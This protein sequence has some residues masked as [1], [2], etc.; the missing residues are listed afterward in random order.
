MNRDERTVFSVGAF[1]AFADPLAEGRVAIAAHP[2]GWRQG[3][4]SLRPIHQQLWLAMDEAL[5]RRF[6][7]GRREWE[8]H[9]SR[10]P[11]EVGRELDAWIAE[12]RLEVRAFAVSAVEARPHGIR[13]IAPD[14]A[15]LNADRAVLATGPDEDAAAT[16]LLR[17]GIGDGLLRPGPMGLGIDADPMSLRVLDG[18]GSSGRPIFALGPVLRGVLWETIAVP[19]IRV[20]A[21]AIARVLLP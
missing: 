2:D 13:L 19:E 12:G 1:R 9:R 17:A 10:L 21:A 4:D 15:T 5:R 8:V 11:G 16:P 18:R 3:L 6:L 7:E 14:G 20:H